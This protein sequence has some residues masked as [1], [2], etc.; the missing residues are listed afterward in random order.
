MKYLKPLQDDLKAIFADINR[1]E[2]LWQSVKALPLTLVVYWRARHMR[3]KWHW[4][5]HQDQLNQPLNVLREKLNIRV[6]A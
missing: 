1:G 2:V 3:N 5:D 4:S 6:I